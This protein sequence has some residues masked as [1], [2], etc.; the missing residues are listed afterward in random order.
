MLKSIKFKEDWRCFKAGELFEFRPGL[1]LLVGDQGS[2]KSSLIEVIKATAARKPGDKHKAIMKKVTFSIE[3]SF[4]VGGF[5]FEKDNYRTQHYFGDNTMFQVHSMFH[6]HGETNL[7]ILKALEHTG[8]LIY[9]DEPDMALSVRSI[10]KLRKKLEEVTTDTQILAVVQNPLIM[11]GL[12]VLSVEH[13]RWM[14][15]T[16]FIKLHSEELSL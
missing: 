1:N 7:Q 10:R 5:D 3:G 15:A 2:G 11:E 13:R 14:P 16:E 9:L 6:S 12:D 8:G 4:P